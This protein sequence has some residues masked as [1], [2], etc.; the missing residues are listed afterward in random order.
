VAVGGGERGERAVPAQPLGALAVEL[1]AEASQALGARGRER[2]LPRRLALQ[3]RP[4]RELRVVAVARARVRV[5]R[6]ADV[7]L[8]LR[9][10]PLPLGV[11]VAE[12]AVL[13]RAARRRDV[14]V[15]VRVG[16]GRALRNFLQEQAR[17][18]FSFR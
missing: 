10:A 18:L 6:A 1:K 14:G 7:R 17:L 3:L 15:G 11:A 5:A 2:A 9:E 4:A 16:A 13:P 8:Q 12:E